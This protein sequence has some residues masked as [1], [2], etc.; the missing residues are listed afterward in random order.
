MADR[1]LRLGVIGLSR[2]FDLTRP[3]LAADPRVA[4]V[5]AADPRPEARAAFTAEFAAPAHADA[6]TLLA[7]PGVEVVYIA[8]P[9]QTHADLAIA[10]AR[11]GKHVLVEKPMALDLAACRAMTEAAR[12]AGVQ[13]LVGPSH[14]FDA[15]VAWAADLI[16]SGALGAPRM[17]TATTFTDF[18]YRPRRPEELDTEQ[19]GGVV[20]SQAAHQVDVVRRLIGAPIASVRAAT[21]RWDPERPAEGAYQ[22]FLTFA[23]GATAALTYSGYGRFDT[24]VLMG[25]IGETGAFKDPDAY[26]VARRRLAEAPEAELKAARAY[27]AAGAKPAPPAG[28]EHFGFVLAACEGAD[29]RLTARGVEIYG[30]DARRTVDLPVGAATRHGVINE[31]WQAIVEGRPPVHDGAWG[32]ENLAVCLAI[33]Q[34]A[35]TGREIELEAPT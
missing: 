21:G 29:L 5:G 27:G 1:V 28:H 31:L 22:A 26:A 24:D 30:P 25:W 13:L 18:L 33:L 23:C 6:A 35:N 3:T 14:G 19:G 11:A 20:F 7:D 16:A 34:S 4:L 9:H 32:E 15:P 17:V 12:E 10:A 2:G 8:T